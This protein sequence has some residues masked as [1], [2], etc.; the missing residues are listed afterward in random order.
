[1]KTCK[2]CD[3]IKP[4]NAFSKR[5]RAKDGLQSSCKVCKA[6]YLQNHYKHNKGKYRA[7]AAKSQQERQELLRS[8]KHMKPCMDCSIAHPYYV[9]DFDHR[10]PSHK[11]NSV[12]ALARVS[13]E[14]M[15]AEIAKCD[16]VCS[17]CHRERTRGK[18]ILP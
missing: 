17:N 3:K 8:L 4:R 14:K 13:T 11:V 5:A 16:L 10:D 6:A 12:S 9:L 18:K 15:L 2:T 7:A 1:M